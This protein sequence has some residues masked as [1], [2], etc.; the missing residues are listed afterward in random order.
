VA[1]VLIDV[2]DGG[3][4]RGWLTVGAL[5][6]LGLENKHTTVL[7]G[8]ALAAGLLLTPGRSALRTP[9]PWAAAAIAL[10]LLLPNLLWQR[11]HGYPSLEFYRN[12]Q[13]EKN[14][15]TPP[16][17]VIAGQIL[18]VG[19]GAAPVWIAGAAWLLRAPAAKPYRLFGYAFA[20]L[21]ALMLASR[22]S[23]PDRIA[24]F[25]PILFAAGAVAIETSTQ[26]ARSR[27]GLRSAQRRALPP[28]P[29]RW[30]RVVA[31]A[32][33]LVSAAA[34]APLALPLLP[35]ATVAAYARTVGL[36]PRIERGKTS[37]IPQW[38]ADRTGWEGFVAD[39]EAV[40]RAL[41]PEDQARAVIYCPSY[42]QAGA[43][44][45]YG[46]QRGLPRVIA[47]QNS[48]WTWADEASLP[49]VLIAVGARE[50]DLEAA[51]ATHRVAAISRCDYC[52]S[53]RNDVPIFVATGP[54]L[55]FR[56]VWDRAR[57]FE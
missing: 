48:Y 27:W 37:P 12:A 43:L 4:R 23:R 46:P 35:P 11:A 24:A 5:L 36:L 51:Y 18:F 22:A 57:H 44:E 45:R 7:L 14:I 49:E 21:F 32:L 6:G 10:L 3:D 54:R 50:K 31:P 55:P 53:W 40:Y 30:L 9:W 19:A 26:S 42:G 8:A 28:S 17:A 33:V 2:L 52:M 15:P 56:E 13:L 38:L 16:L 1:L 34:I 29:R 47:S 25:Y 20:G 41:P 39:V